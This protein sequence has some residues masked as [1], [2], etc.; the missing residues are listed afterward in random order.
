MDIKISSGSV[1]LDNVQDF[2]KKLNEIASV[3]NVTVQALNADKVAGKRHLEFAVN[4]ALRA[5]D[6]GNNRAKDTGIE[7]MRYASGKRQIEDAFSMGV[8]EG[9]NNVAIVILG[10]Y[11]N[12]ESA[13]E[14]IN[15]LISEKTLLDYNEFK[16]DLIVSEFNITEPEINAVGEQKIPDIVLERVALVDVL[17]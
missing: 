5:I 14:S 15:K 17:K 10:Q 7:I 16:K 11:S 1:N 4:K 3:N 9:A 8:H 6:N 13:F 2:I 12:I